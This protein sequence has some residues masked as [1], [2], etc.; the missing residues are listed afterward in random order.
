MADV[1]GRV[2]SLRK[3]LR[4]SA[5]GWRMPKGPTRLGPY[6]S[7][8]NPATLRSTRVVRATT[9]ITPPNT[10]RTMMVFSMRNAV[11]DCSFMDSFPQSPA[12]P[13]GSFTGAPRVPMAR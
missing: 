11:S 13:A 9:P 1:A 3:F 2:S 12:T 6:R 8:M 7:W 5:T 4:P 10:A